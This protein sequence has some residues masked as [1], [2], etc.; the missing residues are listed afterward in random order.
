M[1]FPNYASRLIPLCTLFAVLAPPSIGLALPQDDVS[2]ALSPVSAKPLG[3]DTSPTITT[4]SL[5][6]TAIAATVPE[7]T[8]TL[9]FAPFPIRPTFDNSSRYQDTKN[10]TDEDAPIVTSF[11][12]SSDLT[13]YY[14]EDTEV[15]GRSPSS[16]KSPFLRLLHQSIFYYRL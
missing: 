4:G 15:F 6:P 3:A 1:S 13:T 5:Q 10:Y 8:A 7:N 2:V 14:I 11:K 9:Q 12:N 16:R